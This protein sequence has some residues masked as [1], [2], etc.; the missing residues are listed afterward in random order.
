MK[1]PQLFKYYIVRTTH[2][3]YVSLTNQLNSA[4]KK[5]WPNNNLS[6][7]LSN[8]GSKA[9]IKVDFGSDQPINIPPPILIS[10]YDK[11]NHSQLQDLLKT[12]EW[13]K[14]VSLP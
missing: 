8:D 14:E 9:C 5:T 1:K 13:E 4:H 6:I 11:T 2:P 7:V 10:E 3:S 12:P